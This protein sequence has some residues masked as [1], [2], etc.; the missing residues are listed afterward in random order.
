MVYQNIASTATIKAI[1]AD[2]NAKPNKALGQNFLAAV[3][4]AEKI[5]QIA[6]IT[7]A[8][9]VLEIGPGLGALSELLA[10]Q[11]AE[12]C[13]VELDARWYEHLRLFFIN[14]PQVKLYQADALHFD[15]QATM[16]ELGWVNYKVVANL[17]YHITSPLIKRLLLDGGAWQSLTLMM[18]KEVAQKLAAGQVGPLS[19]LLEYY[20]TA[21]QVLNVPPNAFYPP[22]EIQSAVLQINRHSEPPLPDANPQ[23]LAKLLWAAFGQRRKTLLNSLSGS[24]LGGDKIIWQQALQAAEIDPNHRAEQLSLADFGRLLRQAE[25]AGLLAKE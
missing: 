20:G 15:Y 6:Q 3:Q 23:T 18:Q 21:Q 24:Y 10:A 11:A 5:L 17:P 22:P 7:A 8:D 1:L 19:L 13:L 4:T 25:A 12:L 16:A 14:Q 2:N 9:N